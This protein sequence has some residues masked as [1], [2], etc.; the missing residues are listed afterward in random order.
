MILELATA[1]IA[2]SY[3][4]VWVAGKVYRH[5]LPDGKLDASGCGKYVW[6]DHCGG[7]GYGG[8]VLCRE[9]SAADRRNRIV[10]TSATYW[11]LAGLWYSAKRLF[12]TV[13]LGYRKVWRLSSGETE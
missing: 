5:M 11:P 10:I 2:A 7:P 13:A 3:G 9:C 1:A 12:S 8:V 4:Y 6:P